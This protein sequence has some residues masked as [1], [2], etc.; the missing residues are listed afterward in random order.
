MSECMQ[1]CQKLQHARAPRIETLDELYVIAKK[2]AEVVYQPGT[3]NL[4]PQSHSPAIWLAITEEDDDKWT[5]ADTV[6]IVLPN[7]GQTRTRDTWGCC[8]SGRSGNQPR[9]RTTSCWDN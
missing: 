7:C 1:T 3:Q 6:T 9:A 2:I 5:A 4:Y 8:H